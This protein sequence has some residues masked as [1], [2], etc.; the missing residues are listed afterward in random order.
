M[1]ACA[2]QAEMVKKAEKAEAEKV[3]KAEAE[4][5]KKAEADKAEAQKPETAEAEMAEAEKV[6]VRH[7]SG[8]HATKGAA[9]RCTSN[10]L[11]NDTRGQYVRKSTHSHFA[12]RSI[13]R[14]PLT[15]P[16]RH[17]SEQAREK[18]RVR[19][20]RAHEWYAQ[21]AEAAKKAEKEATAKHIADVVAKQKA[22]PD[23]DLLGDLSYK[24]MVQFP[25]T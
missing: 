8:W 23:L 25:A 14:C 12:A 24:T 20:P 10:A 2:V 16:R 4:K 22:E 19:P 1:H 3:K 6:A 15:R 9:E 11:R 5:V 18:S 13:T 7:V 17:P 21:A